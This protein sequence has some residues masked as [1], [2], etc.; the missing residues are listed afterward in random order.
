MPFTLHPFAA[1]KNGYVTRFISDEAAVRN[2]EVALPV[3]ADPDPVLGEGER[4]W[5]PDFEVLED[6]VRAYGRAAPIEGEA[7][8]LARIAKIDAMLTALEAKAV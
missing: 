7:V 1:V 2:G 8:L 6:R 5:G 4:L 3:I